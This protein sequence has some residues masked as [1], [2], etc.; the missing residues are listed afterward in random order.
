MIIT[1]IT[2]TRAVAA[3]RPLK[4]PPVPALKSSRLFCAPFDRKLHAA[5]TITTP[6]WCLGTGQTVYIATCCETSQRKNYGN[7]EGCSKQADAA[8]SA[9]TTFRITDT[10]R[11]Q[12]TGNA[13]LLSLYAPSPPPHSLTMW[14]RLLLRLKRL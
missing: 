4:L 6:C 1:H 3:I 11:A 10:H 2:H 14:C 8:A 12:H 7:S 9:R 5:P 13:L